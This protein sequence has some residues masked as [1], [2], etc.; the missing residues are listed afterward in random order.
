MNLKNDAYY[1]AGYYTMRAILKADLILSAV[2]GAVA[3]LSLFDGHWQ[4]S[5]FFGFT[6]LVLLKLYLEKKKRRRIQMILGVTLAEMEASDKYIA[7]LEYEAKHAK[8]NT[9]A[10]V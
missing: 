9:N 4:Y 6:A 5:G 8:G 10:Q 3:V 2:F 1:L 7:K